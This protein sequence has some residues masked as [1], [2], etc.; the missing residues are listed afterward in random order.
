MQGAR[1][2]LI[3]KQGADIACS[4]RYMLV[5]AS[6]YIIFFTIDFAVDESE[7]QV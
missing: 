1:D 7:R 5:Q 2:C 6:S 4:Y 3:N